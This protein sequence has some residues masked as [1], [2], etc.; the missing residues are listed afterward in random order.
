MAT[1]AQWISGTRPRTLPNS[2]AP[3]LVGAGAAHHLGAFSALWSALALVVSVSL[4]VGVNFAN[5]YSDGIRGTDEHRVGPFRLVGSGAAE[6]VAVRNAAFAALGLAAVV[7][8][9][10]VLSTGR[11]WMIAFGAVCLA[12]AWFYTGG[13]KP[14]GYSGLGEFAVF[15]FFGPAAVLGTLYVQSGRI[16]WVGVAG[17]VAMGAFSTGV[18][19]ANSLRDIPTDLEAGK[20]TLANRLGDAGARR[21]YLT[22]VTLPFPVTIALSVVVPWTLVGF[23]AVP[24]V[25][26]GVRRVAGGATGLALIPVLRDTGLAMLVW[27]VTVTVALF[28]S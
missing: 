14:Y 9:V 19:I 22:L 2:I 27:G 7:G 1:A 6:P 3:V 23:L 11:Y 15:V 17:A 5:D 12:G 25:I 10:L 24:L 13:R 28:A 8:L 21:L 20:R 18:M 16:G 4:Q 26:P